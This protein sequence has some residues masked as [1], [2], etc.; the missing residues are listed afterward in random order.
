MPPVFGHT[1]SAQGRR[2]LIDSLQTQPHAYVA[3]E[4]VR[5]SQAPVLSR[6]GEFR[7]MNRTVSLRVFAVATGDGNYHVMPG[8]LTRVAPRQRRDVVSMQQGGTSKDVWILSET[9]A[10]A[11]SSSVVP[12]DAGADDSSA[13]I[14]ATVDISSH[15]GE[16]LFWMGRYGER[17]DNLAHILRTTLQATSDSQN[18]GTLQSVTT[19]CRNLGIL[20]AE[21]VK[22]SINTLQQALQ[23]A[24]TDPE[25]TISIATHLRHLHHSGYQVREHL[26]LDNWHVINRMPALLN[27]K[28]LIRMLP[29][30]C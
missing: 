5:L 3:Q 19:L 4:W 7:L 24:V 26:S 10:D 1:L 12:V 9:A 23:L 20:P 25:A 30:T 14:Q 13:V 2:R 15:A 29:C 22:P 21:L 27:E 6:S 16:N 8:G 18:R 28:I 17:A 11:E